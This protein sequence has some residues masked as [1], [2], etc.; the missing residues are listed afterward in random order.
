ME[1]DSPTGRWEAGKWRIL[2]RPR[3][4]RP[5]WGWEWF[6]SRLGGD[7]TW[8]CPVW[9]PAS[10]HQS[11]HQTLW[12]YVQRD[13]RFSDS[14]FFECNFDQMSCIYKY[15]ISV[16]ELS[17]FM[18]TDTAWTEDH[19]RAYTQNHPGVYHTGWISNRTYFTYNSVLSYIQSHYTKDAN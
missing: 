9:H 11:G 6:C 8:G 18:C 14:I 12:T 13:I 15:L 5:R 3:G 7:R 4:K 19:A 17:M 10:P 16:L 2:P 1:G